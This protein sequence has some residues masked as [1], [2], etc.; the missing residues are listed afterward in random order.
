[1]EKHR[2][3]VIDDN[4]ELLSLVVEFLK[5][6]GFEVIGFNKI[7]NLRQIEDLQPGLVILDLEMPGLSG[8]DILKQMRKMDDLKEISVII[9]TGLRER[10]YKEILQLAQGIL[11]KPFCL[12]DL[13]KS[14]CR[15][16]RL[17]NRV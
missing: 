11:E 8:F 10:A 17:K 12:H 15:L 7:F 16:L 2:I 9:V 1:L 3:I 5:E 6:S 13:L 4:E 14:I